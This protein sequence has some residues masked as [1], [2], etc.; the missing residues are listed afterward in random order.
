MYDLPPILCGPPSFLI[1]RLV[2]GRCGWSTPAFP[3]QMWRDRRRQPSLL[4]PRCELLL[5]LLLLLLQ[6]VM[7]SNDLLHMVVSEGNQ[8]S[9]FPSQYS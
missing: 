7:L 1:P 2:T 9:R 5:L 8:G 4:H 6:S 3:G